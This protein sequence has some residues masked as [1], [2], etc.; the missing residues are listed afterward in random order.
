MCAEGQK[1]NRA[2]GNYR[3]ELPFGTFLGAAALA[4][5][6]VGPKVLG[7]YGGM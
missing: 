6:I 2:N 3:A 1:E 7:W 4:A 5:A